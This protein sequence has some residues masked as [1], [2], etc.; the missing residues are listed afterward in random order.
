M[1]MRDLIDRVRDNPELIE[2]LIE[3]IKACE[4]SEEEKTLLIDLLVYLK[5]RSPE[6]YR[7]L[8]EALEE[9]IPREVIE[10][11]EEENIEDYEMR[12]FPSAPRPRLW[13]SR[14]GP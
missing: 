13:P 5:D 6:A 8:R 11:C 14:R 2:E 10:A 3:K 1:T 4:L 12:V 7:K 9:R